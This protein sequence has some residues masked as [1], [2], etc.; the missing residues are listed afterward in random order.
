MIY[1][2]GNLI[3]D[4]EKENKDI[5]KTCLGQITTNELIIKESDVD[6]LTTKKSYSE[7][8]AKL[9]QLQ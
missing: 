1:E 9:Q 6:L 5:R 8:E 4:K 2:I 7:N 3:I